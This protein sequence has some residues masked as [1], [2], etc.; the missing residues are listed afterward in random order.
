MIEPF[1]WCALVSA[2]AA[3]LSE[4]AFQRQIEHM[5]AEER[6]RATERRQERQD[7]ERRHRELC[8]SIERAGR[9]F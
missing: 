2:K 6:Q 9:R 5:T 3:E 8:E 1:L 7:T 4:Q